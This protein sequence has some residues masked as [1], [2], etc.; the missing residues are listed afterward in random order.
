M[1]S[2]IFPVNTIRCAVHRFR[3]EPECEDDPEALASS[4]HIKWT[5]ETW[6][7]V[8]F[9]ESKDT[10]SSGLKSGRPPTVPFKRQYLWWYVGVLVHMAW[11][12]STSGKVPSIQKGI[13][14]FYSNMSSHSGDVSF[15]KD[16]AF[17]NITMPNHLLH[18]GF[19]GEGSG[20]SS[21]TH[22]KHLVHHKKT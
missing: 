7:T 17:S 21:V 5:V 22:W 13:F 4:S 1:G 18:H 3:E 16:L 2:R 15:R 10:V 8:F 20:S 19:V 9:S 14:R 11:A 6:K 12:A